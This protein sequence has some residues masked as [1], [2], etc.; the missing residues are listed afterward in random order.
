MLPV[1]TMSTFFPILGL[2]LVSPLNL[3]SCFRLTSWRYLSFLLGCFMCL[4][5]STGWPQDLKN[6][7]LLEM[8][9]E[10]TIREWRLATRSGQAFDSSFQIH[11]GNYFTRH[12]FLI[13]KQ[14]LNLFKEEKGTH[15]K[16]HSQNRYW[17]QE[18]RE[19]AAA[20]RIRCRTGNFSLAYTRATA[21]YS[22][23]QFLW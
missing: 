10:R 23:N 18:K 6:A 17:Q 4:P 1:R 20:C 5:A 7:T 3:Q 16:A 15:P 22:L 14:T 12:I 2:G 21:S 13:I 19:W 11:N 8:L 9:A